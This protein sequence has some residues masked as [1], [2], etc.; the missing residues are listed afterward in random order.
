MARSNSVYMR[1]SDITAWRSGLIYSNVLHKRIHYLPY[2]SSQKQQHNLAKEQHSTLK[3]W[4]QAIAT[5]CANVSSSYCSCSVQ[6]E[7]TKCAWKVATWHS[8]NLTLKHFDMQHCCFLFLLQLYTRSNSV[9]LKNKD[10]AL[11]KGDISHLYLLRKC[12]QLLLQLINLN[13]LQPLFDASPTFVT[14]TGT[15]KT[16]KCGRR[17]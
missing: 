7:A 12:L 8:W 16:S 9:S 1:C 3:K 2:L 4:R 5:C 14:V 13:N 11:W 10:I 6:T 17:W 15:A